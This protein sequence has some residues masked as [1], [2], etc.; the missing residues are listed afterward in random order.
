MKKADLNNAINYLYNLYGYG[1]S[2]RINNNVFTFF[3]VER[4]LLAY[5]ERDDKH[6]SYKY[7]K[8][9][10]AITDDKS[11]LNLFNFFHIHELELEVKDGKFIVDRFD[12]R[13]YKTKDSIFDQIIDFT[14][15]IK[16]KIKL[17]KELKKK[18]KQEDK[19]LKI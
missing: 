16:Y 7:N 9:I 11:M 14:N 15:T 17:E 2:F 10:L 19:K 12:G 13:A 6:I 4:D 1:N 8:N 3:K 18:D 5:E